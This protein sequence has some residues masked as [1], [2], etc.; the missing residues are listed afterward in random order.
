MTPATRAVLSRVVNLELLL[1]PRLKGRDEKLVRELVWAA[2]EA[3]KVEA[4]RDEAVTAALAPLQQALILL[5]CDRQP[6]IMLCAQCGAKYTPPGRCRCLPR[7]SGKRG[8]L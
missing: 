6:L 2:H 4:A 8:A 5:E 1:M 3:L 7:K